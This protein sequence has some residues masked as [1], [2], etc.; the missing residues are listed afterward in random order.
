[1]QN[2]LYLCMRIMRKD[3]LDLWYN[4]KSEVIF[5][6][7]MLAVVAL[8]TYLSQFIPV[9]I[10]DHVLTPAFNVG[11]ITAAFAC[12]WIVFRHLEHMRIRRMWGYALLVWGLGDLSYLVCYLIEPLQ[13]MNMGAEHIT[14]YELLIG[15]LL[16]W[17]MIL[18]PTE[19]LRPGWLTPKV[20]AWQLMPMTALVA[21]D[22]VVPFSLRPLIALYPYALLALVLTH[23]RE[24]RRWC[25]NN[26][27]SMDNIDVQWIIRYC[28]ML[29][30]IGINYTNICIAQNHTR[31]F[32][33]QWFVIFMIVYS[34]EQ[35][36]YR[37][38]PWQ[39]L[40]RTAVEE[41]TE[42]PNPANAAY[43][44]TLEAWIESEKPYCNPDFQ[45]TDL[46]QVLPLNRTY[47]SQFINS[48][49][50]CSFYQWVN[51]LR[52]K[53]AKRLKMEH[54]EWTAQDI[55][56]Q[57]C[58]FSSRQAVY[59]TFLRETGQTLS[60]WWTEQNSPTE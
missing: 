38:D 37:K 15:N 12:A 50:G 11:T 4:Y 45:L 52:I 7:V 28:I 16:G 47:L 59:R 17:V 35:I 55:V 60:E 40:R 25:E 20:I 10:Y 41:V 42:E 26:F 30:I 19:T 53:E 44:A 33:Q 32:T 6:L 57:G 2:L 14:V 56:E 23:I 5:G 3:I 9:P 13:I 43:R 51:G 31:A 24:Y 18:Y 34:T 27:S 46:R 1:M 8:S 58:G 22:Y 29:A 36:L 54:P 21:L 48:E 49:Y 39:H